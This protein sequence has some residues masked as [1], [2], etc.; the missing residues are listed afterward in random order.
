[1]PFPVA[2]AANPRMPAIGAACDGARV[3]RH[4]YGHAAC[5]LTRIEVAARV[6]LA[7]LRALRTASAKG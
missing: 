1:M 4:G 2:A 3:P 5:A 6:A 7:R